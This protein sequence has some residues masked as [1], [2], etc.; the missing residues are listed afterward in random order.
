MRIFLLNNSLGLFVDMWQSSCCQFRRKGLTNTTRGQGDHFRSVHPRA[1]DGLPGGPRRYDILLW[2]LK[3]ERMYHS[4]LSINCALFR[5]RH[6]GTSNSKRKRSRSG[7]FVVLTYIKDFQLMRENISKFFA[8][9]SK[10]YGYSIVV[11]FCLF[12]KII[13]LYQI[14]EMLAKIFTMN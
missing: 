7:N 6:C 12:L 2:N 4:Y 8:Y 10:K 9:I 5:S 14:D 13:Y 1:R 11:V 3:N